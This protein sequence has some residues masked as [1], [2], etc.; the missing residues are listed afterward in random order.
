MHQP[1]ICSTGASARHRVVHCPGGGLGAG[2]PGGV[3]RSGGSP[4]C[5]WCTWSAGGVRGGGM[6][7]WG[8]PLHSVNAIWVWRSTTIR[9]LKQDRMSQKGSLSQHKPNC[10]ICFITF[11]T[12]NCLASKC[13]LLQLWYCQRAI[14]SLNWYVHNKTVCMLLY[15]KS[16][17]NTIYTHLSK[18]VKLTVTSMLKRTEKT[19]KQCLPVCSST[20]WI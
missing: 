11:L 14:W 3:L 10:I 18:Y 2:S 5:A 17:E 6:P 7:V 20:Q 9:S 12:A 19:V 16:K 8:G 13:R 4:V 15:C 1:S